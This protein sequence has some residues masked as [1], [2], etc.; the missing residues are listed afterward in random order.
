VQTLRELFEHELRA[1]AAFERGLTQALQDMADESAKKDVS[2]AFVRQMKQTERQVKRLE[3]VGE[4]LQWTPEPAPSPALDG[5]LR[6]KE[7]FVA[8]APTDDLLDY[9]NLRV[10]A[11]LAEYAAAVYEGL[12]ETAER[13]QLPRVS[14]LLRA[15]LEEMRAAVSALRTLTHEYDVAFRETGGL[16]QPVPEE[17]RR[18]ARALVGG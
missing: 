14:H 15:S 7:A 1:V 16:L 6:E 17:H 5:V 9:Y 4:R 8:A 10:A 3:K 2:R 11:R 18:Q 12:V 13:L